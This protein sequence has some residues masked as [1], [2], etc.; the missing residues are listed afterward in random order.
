[1]S[2]SG[3]KSLFFSWEMFGA[4]H[5]LRMVGLSGAVA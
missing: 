4:N 3:V 5:E 1:M 2:V